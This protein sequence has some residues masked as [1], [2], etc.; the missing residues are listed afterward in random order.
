[1]LDYNFKESKFKPLDALTLTCTQIFLKKT[2]NSL[3]PPV[4]NAGLQQMLDYNF[5][6]SK[7]KPQSSSNAHLY[8]N[9]LEKD[10]E[11]SYPSSYALNSC[12]IM[13]GLALDN[14]WR[15][16]YH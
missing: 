13:T 12:S 11:L 3:I 16:I 1:M 2:L 8:T 5:K 7:F 15:L 14:P 6:E 4:K 10:I 9:F